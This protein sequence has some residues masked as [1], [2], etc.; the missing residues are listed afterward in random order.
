MRVPDQQIFRGDLSA[1]IDRD[2][3]GSETPDD[4]KALVPP[5]RLHLPGQGGPG[6]GEVD[7]HM[8]STVDVEVASKVAKQLTLTDRKS[9]RLNSSH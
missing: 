2:L 4:A 6:N 7:G 9:T 5:D 3:V 1:R 8:I